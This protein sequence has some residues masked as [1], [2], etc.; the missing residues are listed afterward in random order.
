[1]LEAEITTLV[2]SDS[3]ACYKPTLIYSYIDINHIWQ[4]ARVQESHDE[5]L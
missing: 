4:F 5:G 2:S 1:M 3:T